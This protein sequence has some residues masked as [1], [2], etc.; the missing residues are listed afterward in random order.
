MPHSTRGPSPGR[1]AQTSFKFP[2]DTKASSSS[3]RTSM[4]KFPDLDTSD[5]FEQY[6]GQP[7]Y[8][9]RKSNGYPTGG[10]TP[11]DRWQPQRNGRMRGES[12]ANGE[13]SN[14]RGH[15]KQKSISDAFRTITS[16]RGSVS[17]NVHEISD[18]LKAPVSPKLIVCKPVSYTSLINADSI[19]VDLMYRVV[20]FERSDKHIFKIHSEC[21]PKTCDSH[22]DTICICRILLSLFLLALIHFPTTQKCNSSTA[23]W[24]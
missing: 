19:H 23:T 7:R 3:S 16:R 14:S 13:S 15:T 12:W 5:T 11:A 24:N 2:G 22:S 6:D 1:I 4:E 10:S 18:A 8:N 17:A 21:I 20:F 9:S